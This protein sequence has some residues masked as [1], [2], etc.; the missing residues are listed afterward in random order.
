M[1]YY[2]L[3]IP[4][5]TFLIITKMVVTESETHIPT[6]L[7]DPFEPVTRRFDSSLRKGSSDLPMDD[8][9]LKKNATSNFP[10]QIALAI[11]SSTSIWVSWVTGTCLRISQSFYFVVVVIVCFGGVGELGLFVLV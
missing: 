6:T 9:R 3:W 8:P 11:S 1:K 10:E 5:T 7:E 2:K 4:L